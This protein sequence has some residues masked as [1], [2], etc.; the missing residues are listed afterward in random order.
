MYFSKEE[1]VVCTL[2][3]KDEISNAISIAS[4]HRLSFHVLVSALHW[5]R[6]VRKKT[7][8][9]RS[10]HDYF[11]CV[12][13]YCDVREFFPPGNRSVTCGSEVC[14]VFQRKEMRA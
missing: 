4:L 10:C 5:K 9:K 6:N 2:Y 7:H 11:S 14:P 12:S 1:M 13:L 3:R 8:S